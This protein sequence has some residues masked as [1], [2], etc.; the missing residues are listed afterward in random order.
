MFCSKEYWSRVGYVCNS[1]NC[2]W[3][4]SDSSKRWTTRADPISFKAHHIVYIDLLLHKSTIVDA[5]MLKVLK[6]R[7]FFIVFTILSIYQIVR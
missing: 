4:F 3:A 6:F 2:N 7:F 5:L 1:K